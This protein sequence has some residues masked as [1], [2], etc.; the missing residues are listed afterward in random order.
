[1]SCMMRISQ[2]CLPYSY[3]LWIIF[4]HIL[5]IYNSI[6]NTLISGN[7]IFAVVSI[8]NS[9]IAESKDVCLLLILIIITKLH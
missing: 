5:A 6:K 1:M 9:G 3:R 8:P 4:L 7:I 2:Y